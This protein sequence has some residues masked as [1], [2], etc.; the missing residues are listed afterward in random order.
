MMKRSAPM[1]RGK[2]FKR[3]ERER[4][5]IVHK[6]LARLPNYAAS[7]VVVPVP[8]AAPTKPGKRA[9]TVAESAWM[10]A[11]TALGC[12]A[13]L[14]DGHPDTPGAVHHLLS[15]GRRMGHL[16]TIC[17][18]D[19]GHHQNGQQF[20]KVS[21]HPHKARF[22]AQYGTEMELLDLTQQLVHRSKTNAGAAGE[23]VTP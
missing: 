2:G 17:L 21:R 7:T 22:E 10:D 8:K 4:A 6:P 13:C 20:G 9:P 15:G 3:P 18:C 5:P 19:P 12:I 1:N 14:Q 23:R 11:I 16:F